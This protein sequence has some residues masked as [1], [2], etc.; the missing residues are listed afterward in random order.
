[1]YLPTLELADDFVEGFCS[2]VL[3]AAAAVPAAAVAPAPFGF[4]VGVVEV[5]L[6]FSR[7]LYGPTSPV[8]LTV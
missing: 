2:L 3:D 1:L 6:Y 4:L 5:G 8:A 7:P